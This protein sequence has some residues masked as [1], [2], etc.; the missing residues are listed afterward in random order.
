MLDAEAAGSLG[1]SAGSVAYID[2][3]PIE[4]GPIHR[5]A[6]RIDHRHGVCVYEILLPQNAIRAS[7][8]LETEAAGHCK[9]K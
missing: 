7:V 4:S 6:W 2:A 1:G 3:S 9:H 8:S 5:I